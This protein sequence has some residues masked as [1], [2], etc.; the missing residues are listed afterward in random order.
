MDTVKISILGDVCPTKDYRQFWDDGT[1]FKTVEEL[2]RDSDLAVVNLEC[3]ATEYDRPMMKCGPCLKAKPQDVA[4]LKNVGFHLI[5]LANNHIK[6]YQE[7]GVLDTIEQCKLNGL[8]YVGAGENLSRAKEARFFEIKKKRIGVLSFA[9][10]EFNIATETQAGANFFDVYESPEFIAECKKQCDF[11]IVLY[12]GGIEHYRYP[13]EHLQKKCRLLVRCGA[14]L[15][16]CQHSHCIGTYEYYKDGYILYGQGNGVYGYRENSTAWNEG[17]LLSIELNEAVDIKPILLSAKSNGVS[18]PDDEIVEKR[19]GQ[20]N[21][22]SKRLNDKDF[23]NKEWK[24][25]CNKNGALNR[26]LFYGKSRISIKLNRMTKNKFFRMSMPKKREMVTM[27][28]VRCDS[29][30]EVITT[31]LETD[32]YDE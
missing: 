22:E 14:N 15:V 16:I 8:A 17:L 19:L 18:I 9:E 28:L 24:K 26:P 20:F 11:L 10:K 25:F 12:H 1:A 27:N 32:V 23:L 7:E 29:W 2:V 13:S 6:D 31:L 3:P 5:S 21:D 4:L 30:Q